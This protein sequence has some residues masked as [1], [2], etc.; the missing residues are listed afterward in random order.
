MVYE[1]RR[2]HG[3]EGGGVLQALEAGAFSGGWWPIRS[4]SQAERRG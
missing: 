1:G 3:G 4:G 2:E